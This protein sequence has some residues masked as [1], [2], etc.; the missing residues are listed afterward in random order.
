MPGFAFLWS[1]NMHNLLKA[2]FPPPAAVLAW[3]AFFLAGTAAAEPALRITPQHARFADSYQFGTV[4]QTYEITNTGKT[5]VAIQR[6]EARS[7]AGKAVESPA[8]LAPGASG[9][10]VIELPLGAS[11][12]D[13]AFRFALF[14]DEK[15]VERYR[16]TL[17]GFVQNAFEP[18]TPAVDLGTVARGAA[19][20]RTLSLDTRE[21]AQWS[22]GEVVEKPEHTQVSVDGH[23]ISVSL[24]A[25]APP[26]WLRGRVVLNTSLPQQPQVAVA[27]TGFVMGELLLEAKA[28]SVGST[29]VGKEVRQSFSVRGRDA[30]KLKGKISARTDAP[31]QARVRECTPAADDCVTID[32][33]GKPADAGPIGGTVLV[34][35]A[36]G[37]DPALPVHF[38]GVAL[39]PGQPLKQVNSA[40]A[41]DADE[42][43]SLQSALAAVSGH[44]ASAPASSPATTAASAPASG[45]AATAAST[46][47][48]A[49]AE[50]RRS[51]T[52]SGPAR[53][54]WSAAN[55]LRLYGYIVYRA[56]DRAGPFQRISPQPIHVLRDE[57]QVHKYSFEDASV[58][59]GK[60]YYYYIDAIDMRGKRER[61]MPVVEKT[62]K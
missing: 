19:A 24:L 40:A 47:A 39:H 32:L 51:A 21:A 9:K 50:T 59:A 8:Q 34:E 48:A 53:L 38:Y 31:W 46:P 52:G 49:P 61:F 18:E 17:G 57:Q 15:D 20:S 41:A 12:G 27:V 1:G 6:I 54:Q 58:T 56:E 33:S 2:Q 5:P 4:R 26:G 10:I 23:T 28:V 14:S 13:A 22:L 35:L 7:R 44:T 45:P 55:E 43:P 30:L 37:K 3:L 16:F 62:V 42:P 36:G 11:L 25:T 29:E 60:T